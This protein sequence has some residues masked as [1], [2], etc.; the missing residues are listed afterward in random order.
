MKKIFCLNAFCS[1]FAWTREIKQTIL[2][3]YP[4][5]SYINQSDI[6][7]QVLIAKLTQDEDC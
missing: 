5:K 2:C 1:C 6:I 4:L 7:K 3:L